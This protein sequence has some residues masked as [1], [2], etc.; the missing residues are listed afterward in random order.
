MVKANPYVYPYKPFKNLS[1]K[2]L[3]NN[4]T[5]QEFVGIDDI[6]RILHKQEISSINHKEEIAAKKILEIFLS[7]DICFDSEDFIKENYQGWIKKLNYFIDKGK[8][9][10]FSILGFPFKVPVP[11]KTNRKLPDLGE[12]L[13][14]NRLNNIMELIEKIYSPGAKVT[15]FTEGIFGSFVGLEKKEAD[16]YRDYLIKI[17]EN[18]NLSNVIIQDLR[19]LEEFVPNFEKEFQLEKE[20]MLKLYEKK[21]RDFM[22][23]Y[24]GTA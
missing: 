22:R 3:L 23:K 8:R 21:D 24:N 20:K 14:L 15:V 9:I 2:K 19:V 5:D 16:A 12:L 11:L 18:L 10:E 6:K 4:F 1:N 17:K 7:N 13:S